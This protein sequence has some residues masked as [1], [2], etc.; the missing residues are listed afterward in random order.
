MKFDK[1]F[2]V[3][4]AVEDYDDTIV[5]VVKTELV[6]S[7]RWSLIY[8]QVFKMLDTGKYYYTHFRIG[9]TENQ[10]ERPYEYECDE[11]ECQE[12][13]PVEKTIVDYEAIKGENHGS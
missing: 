9:A 7:S 12:V 10:D 6:D 3:E 2:L 5:E 1:K 13:V 4:L 8:S 11:I